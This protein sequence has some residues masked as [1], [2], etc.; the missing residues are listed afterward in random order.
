[1]NI[2]A[3]YAKGDLEQV[4]PI[5]HVLKARYDLTHFLQEGANTPEV[6]TDI[7][8]SLD[9]VHWVII[10]W[11][12]L[13]IH[14]KSVH[15]IAAQASIKGLLVP[16]L[17]DDTPF[18]DK[19]TS[20]SLSDLPDLLVELLGLKDWVFYPPMLEEAV[21]VTR[22]LRTKNGRARRAVRAGRT[23]TWGGSGDIPVKRAESAF[24]DYVSSVI[25]D[26]DVSWHKV[27]EEEFNNLPMGK[28]LF[29][30]ADTMRT[31]VRERVEVR[32]AKDAKVNLTSLLRGRGIPEELAI[33]VYPTMTVQLTGKDFDITS[34]SNA[35]QLI[36]P[37]GYTEWAWDVTPQKSGAK[38]LHLRVTLRIQLGIGEEHKEHP[39]MDRAIAVKVNA[40][41]STKVFLV[42]HWKLILA[43]IVLPSV[44]YALKTYL[45]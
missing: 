23:L 1:M 21:A 8:R 44:T 26:G 32:I 13:S 20:A 3:S 43:S 12:T 45:G 36:D 28:I 30:P 29:N 14:S 35:E 41:Y 11:S 39:I 31:G 16:I 4:S 6:R 40:I 5:L 9:T 24:P 19:Y 27:L 37:T 15:E 18:P 17:L 34:H 33:K 10:F 7:S 42:A 2:L 38:T 22:R 25:L